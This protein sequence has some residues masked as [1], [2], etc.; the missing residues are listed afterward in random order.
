[1]MKIKIT[2]N[3]APYIMIGSVVMMAVITTIGLL[4]IGI[5]NANKPA[6]MWLNV[7]MFTLGTVFLLALCWFLAIWS[8]L[9][10]PLK[11]GQKAATENKP[12]DV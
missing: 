6:P 5:E 9:G 1:M 11:P 4:V 7:P 3:T 10:Q 8:G 12:G 2:E